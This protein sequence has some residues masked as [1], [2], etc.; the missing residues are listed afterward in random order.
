[1]NTCC[2][3]CQ[4]PFV[5]SQTCFS[6]TCNGEKN[7]ST[8]EEVT[9]DHQPMVRANGNKEWR[10]NGQLHRDGDQPAVVRADG[11]KFWYKNG[12][13]H[14]DGDQPAVVWAGG[15]KYWRKNGKLHRDGDQPAVVRVNGAKEWWKNGIQYTL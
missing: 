8:I 1:M 11:S 14:R 2:P 15:T 3:N 7:S 13:V 10:K 6:S 5:F 12:Q 4:I 9:E